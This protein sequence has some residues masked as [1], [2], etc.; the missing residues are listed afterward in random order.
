MQHLQTKLHASGT[1]FVV[2]L[3]LIHNM[4]QTM[5]LENNIMQHLKDIQRTPSMMDPDIFC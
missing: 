4:L 3:I 1:D 5:I 2:L